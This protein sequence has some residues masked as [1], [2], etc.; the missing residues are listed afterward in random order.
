MKMIAFL[1]AISA[2]SLPLANAN[3][4]AD[5]ASDDDT[6]V[7]TGQQMTRGEAHEMATKYTRAV[8]APS[9][10]EQNARWSLPICIGVVGLRDEHA[11]AIIDRIE[12]SAKAAGARVASAGCTPN[13]ILTFVSDS[14]MVFADLY[15][16]R[17][18][19][20]SNTDP[21]EER[22]LKEKGLPVRWFYSQAVEGLGGRATLAGDGGVPILSNIQGSRIDSPAQVSITGCTVLVDIPRVSRV[23]V[24][25]LTDYI[26]FAVLSRTRI[27]AA[28][29]VA[30]IMNLFDAAEADRPAGM[31]PMDQA[32]LRALY[33][34]PINRRSAVHNSQMASEMIKEI[35]TVP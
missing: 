7:V 35:A 8:L 4:Q 26:A 9:V 21:Q 33:R 28:P 18:D 19:L 11:L 13:V 14:D 30:S 29:G 24:D 2:A 16:T 34:I 15:R 3:A 32:M 5:P 31:T 22:K 6:I 10:A 25:A 17:G 12:A 23:T 1:A 27:G 20:L